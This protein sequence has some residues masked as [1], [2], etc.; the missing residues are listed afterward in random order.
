MQWFTL[1]PTFEIELNESRQDAVKKIDEAYQRVENRKLF[2]VFGDYGELHVPPAEH[3]VWSPHLAF[4]IDQRGEHACI[5]GRF[6]PRFEIWTFVWICYM[7][8]AC[9]AFFGFILGFS[10]FM[11]GSTAW[12]TWIGVAAM[13]LWAILIAVA[14][15]GQQLSADQ[16]RGL[17]I[18]LQEFLSSARLRFNTDI[19]EPSAK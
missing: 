18:Q 1:R 7:A 19:A 11:I 6:A 9:T 3:R 16:M 13:V 14:H 10:Q 2:Q 17:Q 12:G 8:L 15:I 4:S 5:H